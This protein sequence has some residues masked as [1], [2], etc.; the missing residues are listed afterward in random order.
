[1]FRLLLFILTMLPA[2]RSGAEGV[3]VSTLSGKVICGYQGWFRC[4]GDGSNNGWHHYSPRGDP[5]PGKIGIDLWPDVSDLAATDRVDT[6]FLHADGRAAQLFSS[7]KSGVTRVHFQW[8]RQ[9]G[10]DG[11]L[12]QRFATTTSD[13]R[14][15][16]PMDT[17]LDNVKASTAATGRGWALMYDLS[18]LKPGQMDTVMEDFKRLQQQRR[19][20]RDGSDRAYFHHRGKP[21]VGVWGLGFNDREPMLDEWERLIHFLRDDKEAGG[22]SILLGVPCYWRTQSKDCI[23]DTKL[24]ALLEKADIISPWS[25][26]RFGTAQD[27]TART[28]ELLRPDIAKAAEWKSDYLPVIFPGFSWQNLQKSRGKEAKLDQIP[29]RG[30]EFLWSQAVAAKSAGVNMLYVAMFDEL[31][32]GTAIFKTTSDAPVGESKFVAEPAVKPDHYLWLTGE[33]GKMLRA[34]RPLERAVPRRE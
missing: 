21:L 25:V 23:A 7:V 19:I 6:S 9:Y 3:D 16:G 34:E 29:R 15:R 22:F 14:F 30:G 20:V 17:V 31:D 2:L 12:L 4:A 28:D 5:Q 32:E 27:A 24:H 26:G 13:S 1:M 33:I 10:I 18:G 11:V 8:M